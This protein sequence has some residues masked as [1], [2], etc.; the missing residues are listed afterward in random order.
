MYFVFARFAPTAILSRL[1][2]NV[3][4]RRS[5]RVEKSFSRVHGPHTDVI[6]ASLNSMY[7]NTLQMSLGAIF[8]PTG[9]FHASARSLVFD[10]ETNT[11]IRLGRSSL[12]Y[13]ETYDDVSGDFVQYICNR[14]SIKKSSI[15]STNYRGA[16]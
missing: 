3:R 14:Q 13:R 6:A 2:R 15:S 8:D 5:D 11:R 7:G 4:G 1:D 10:A 12:S 9:Q 16:T